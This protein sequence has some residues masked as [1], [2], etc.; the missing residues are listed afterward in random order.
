VKRVE[1]PGA[2]RLFALGASLPLGQGVAAS[3]GVTLS[4]HVERDFEDGEHKTR[5]A[6]DVRGCDVYVLHSLYGDDEQSAHDKLCRILFF[7]AALRDAGAAEVTAITPYLCYGRKDRRT[8]PFDPVMTRYV[9]Q[10]FEAVGVDRVV[11]MD[12]HNPAAFENAFR[13]RTIHLEALPIFVEHLHGMFGARPLVVFS[14]DF[15]GGKRAEQLRQALEQAMG[16]PVGIGFIEKHRSGGELTGG[17]LFAGDV[18]GRT[19]IVLD[20]LVSTGGTVTRAAR[21]CK[22]RGAVAVVAAA[23]HGLF[24]DGARGLFGEPALDAVV[25]TNTVPPFRVDSEARGKLTVLDATPL[26]ADA[27]RRMHQ[28]FRR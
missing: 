24:I 12:H 21:A 7:C 10:L 1:S 18:E 25:A 17:D 20:D 6:D 23:T 5:P 3:L 9:A 19:V 15:G 28:G 27:V 8:R 13:I 4:E 14:P 2:L 11:A 16:R 26:L 22:R